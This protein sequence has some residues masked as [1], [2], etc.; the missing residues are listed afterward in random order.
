MK[1]DDDKL[2]HVIL[3]GPTGVGKTQLARQLNKQ[4][5]RC[6]I[7]MNELLEWNINNN[8]DASKLAQE[9]LAKL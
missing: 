7:N 1:V 6:I 3:F 5:K 4:H 9:H 8:T 2:H